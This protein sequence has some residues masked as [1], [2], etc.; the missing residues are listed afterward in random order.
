MWHTVAL[1]DVTHPF[2]KCGGII[3]YKKM[4]VV[5]DFSLLLRCEKGRYT[6]CVLLISVKARLNSKYFSV[7]VR[8]FMNL[9]STDYNNANALEVLRVPGICHFVVLG[10]CLFSL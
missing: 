7:F 5:T 6:C 9:Q 8:L 4:T 3:L 10:I 2:L 1:C